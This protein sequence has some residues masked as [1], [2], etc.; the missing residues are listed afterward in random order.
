MK[1]KNNLNMKVVQTIISLC[2]VSEQSF[3]MNQFNTNWTISIICM[4]IK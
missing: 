1:N 2:F 4:A 3:K